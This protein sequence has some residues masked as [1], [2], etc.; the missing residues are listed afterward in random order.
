MNDFVRQ[1][2]E[3]LL[4]GLILLSRIGDVVSTYLVTPTL[5]LEANPVVRRLRWPFAWFT[6]SACLIA[7]YSTAVGFAVVVGSLLVCFWNV[8]KIW[9]ARAI[10]EDES[11][12]L[13]IRTAAKSRLSHALWPLAVASATLASIGGLFIL[14][15]GGWT[16]W[17]YW[18]GMGLVAAGVSHFVHQASAFVRIFRAARG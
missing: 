1:H 13:L 17:A 8:S 10:G 15:S 3:H 11:A 18:G 16:H 5:K 14:T 6:L 2:F 9:F 7:Y 12:A 4:C